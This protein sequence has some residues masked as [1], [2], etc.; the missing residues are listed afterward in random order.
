[1]RRDVSRQPGTVGAPAQISVNDRGSLPRSTRWKIPSK[2]LSRSAVRRQVAPNNSFK[3]NPLRGSAVIGGSM[4]G[5]MTARVLAD[6]F[7]HSTVLKRD[8]IENRLVIHKSVPQG[9]HLHGLLP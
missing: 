5:L 6:Y 8:E 3:P 7:G 9:N 4:A 1:M 2:P